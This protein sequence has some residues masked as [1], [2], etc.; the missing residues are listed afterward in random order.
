MMRVFGSIDGK[1]VPIEEPG[2]DTWVRITDP[3]EDELRT[4]ASKLNIDLR[5]L[6]AAMDAQ[7]SSRWESEDGLISMIVDI[8]YRMDYGG[9]D[10]LPLSIIVK[11]NMVITVCT[12]E[13][14]IFDKHIGPSS[15]DP[16]LK[17]KT[18]FVISLIYTISKEYQKDLN[19]IDFRRREAEKKLYRGIDDTDMVELHR[20]ETSLVYFITSLKG[21]N[22]VLDMMN[23][24]ID[25]KTNLA[26][27][28]KLKDVMIENQ[29]AIEMASIYRETVDSTR[30]LF[31][32]VLNNKLNDVMR[33]LTA[34]TII[35]SV[36]MIISG[37]F[38][39][40]VDI[41]FRSDSLGFVYV[42]SG[43]ILICL[44]TT[45]WLKHRDLI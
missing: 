19:E 21:C 16:D 43:M 39:M 13:S 37:I 14:N 27:K 17:D 36:P 35:L 10:T 30:G 24:H 45:I 3:S 15:K 40:N 8:P 28:E 4:L 25:E 6:T 44:A 22:L 5:K 7:E 42:M 32:S 11:D 1:L 12:I 9:F 38:G 20:M 34:V 31:S 33:W 23:R 26:H 29:Q 18:D 41:P 2:A